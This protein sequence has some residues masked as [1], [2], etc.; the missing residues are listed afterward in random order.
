MKAEKLDQR[1]VVS[2][3]ELLCDGQVAS[4]TAEALSISTTVEIDSITNKAQA[5]VVLLACGHI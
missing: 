1:L 5:I 4:W 2:V 3:L